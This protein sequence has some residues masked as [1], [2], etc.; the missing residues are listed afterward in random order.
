V[1]RRRSG[2]RDG[3]DDMNQARDFEPHIA[4]AFEELGVETY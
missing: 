2:D 4:R 1:A 3:R